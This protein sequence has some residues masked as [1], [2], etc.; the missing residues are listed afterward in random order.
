MHQTLQTALDGLAQSLGLDNLKLS[1]DAEIAIA[2]D[3]V[4]IGISLLPQTGQVRLLSIIGDMP[5]TDSK[6]I[7]QILLAANH[8]GSMTGGAAIGYDTE[9]DILTLNHRLPV[10]GISSETLAAALE[11][12]ANVT[13]G[14]RQ[15]LPVLGEIDAAA[16]PAAASGG[17]GSG[18]GWVRV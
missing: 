6:E 4:E 16:H 10:V 3:D 2:I 17:E 13:T 1:A 18:S 7:A 5:E 9:A 12:M 15:N 14:W 8:L 11:N